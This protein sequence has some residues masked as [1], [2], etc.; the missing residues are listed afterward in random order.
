[1][2]P[3]QR[4]AIGALSMGYLALRHLLPKRTAVHERLRERTSM[5]SWNRN[6]MIG[7]SD[8]LN[9]SSDTDV[10]LNLIDEFRVH[11]ESSVRT[12]SFHMNRLMHE[13]EAELSRI[14]RST[15]G[16][17]ASLTPS[18]RD[19]REQLY[20]QQDV[21]PVIRAHLEGILHNHMLRELM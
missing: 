5:I 3:R 20:V 6:L 2:E 14:L 13:I 8:V 18:T 7:L 11:D 19:L 16:A 21:V 12:A 9:V 17:N 15:G 4:V 10:L 1:M